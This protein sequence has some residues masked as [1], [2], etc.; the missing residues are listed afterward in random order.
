MS[1]W[2]HYSEPDPEFEQKREE[3]KGG[4]PWSLKSVDDI[5]P[6]RAAV[7]KM[8]KQMLAA[9]EMPSESSK[10]WVTGAFNS[11]SHLQKV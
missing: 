4:M 6:R 5:A 9:A 3:L 8:M 11:H 7:A 2:A 1:Q 10:L